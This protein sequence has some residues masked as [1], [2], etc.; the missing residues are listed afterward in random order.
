[1]KRAATI[2]VLALLQLQ[3]SWQKLD[4]GTDS[5]PSFWDGAGLQSKAATKKKFCQTKPDHQLKS[6]R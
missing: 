2:R 1:M 3:N 6:Q 4:A 5:E